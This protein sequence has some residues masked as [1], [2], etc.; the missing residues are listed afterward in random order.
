[1][2]VDVRYWIWLQKCLG[3]GAR[4]L[5]IIEEFGSVE[6]LYNATV[7]DWKMSTSLT[8]KQIDN[9]GKFDLKDT[10][11]IIYNCQKN[12]WQIIAFDNPLYP[13]RLK[14][15]VNPPAVIYVDG[16]LPNVDSMVTIGVVGT[17]K[18]SSYATKA[19]H[20]MSKGIASCGALVISGGALG[21]DS[22]AHRGALASGGKTIAVLGSG[23]GADYLKANE[24]LR[25]EIK[26][27]GALISEYPPFAP[28]TR[29]T[30]PLRN[31]LISGLSLG[32]LV[33]E[34]GVKSG[35]LI[36]ANFANEQGRDVYA[37]PASIFDY[38]FYGTNKLIDDGATVATSPSVLIERYAEE[39]KSI[40]MSKMKTVRE[41]LEDVSDKSA[42]APKKEQVTFD[43]I[44]EDRRQQVKKQSTAL[45][46]KGDEEKVFSALT[47]SFEV[48]DVIVQKSKIETKNALVALTM[49]EM[50]GLVESTS[51]KRYKLK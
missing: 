30:F 42:N 9:L 11:E 46:L 23:L 12:N 16:D 38:N 10:E 28:A 29:T 25:N 3:A 19:A 44:A 37:I 34:A 22:A 45:E 21:V 26:Q 18:A 47:E 27:N 5:E 49:L 32:V 31:R 2:S 24:N 35:S 33:V 40:D 36:T 17:R 39:Y 14:T 41:L 43:A 51:G 4:F 50:K 7:I 6:N 20:I 48:I 1:M 15:I 8:S 13:N